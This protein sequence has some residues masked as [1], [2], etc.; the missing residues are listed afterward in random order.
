MPEHGEDPGRLATGHARCARCRV[1]F[2]RAEAATRVACPFCASPLDHQVSPAE[3]LGLPL[4][5]AATPA[6]ATREQS[7]VQA[8]AEARAHPWPGWTP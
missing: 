1:R 4:F 2:T 5:P 3:V 6:E 7:L 8:V